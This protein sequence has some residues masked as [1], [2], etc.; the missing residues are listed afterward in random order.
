LKAAEQ[1]LHLL[2][3]HHPLYAQAMKDYAISLSLLGEYHQS[4]AV[5][6]STLKIVQKYQ[7]KGTYIELE[8]NFRMADNEMDLG[9]YEL[10]LNLG[11]KLLE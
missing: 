5:Y 4:Q 1:A 11:N 7:E 8:L 10:S 6:K 2:G 9:N 3:E